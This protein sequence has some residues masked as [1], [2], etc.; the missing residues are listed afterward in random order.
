MP[1]I[2][3]HSRET[4]YS[5]RVNIFKGTGKMVMKYVLFIEVVKMILP[6][7]NYQIMTIIQQ[8]REINISLSR[9]VKRLKLK[10][11]NQG[12]INF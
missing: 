8:A 5:C 4:S 11:G 10:V 12:Y 2:P 1:E 6:I 7:T 9:M 3:I